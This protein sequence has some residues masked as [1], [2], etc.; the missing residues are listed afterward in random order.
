MRF[1]YIRTQRL[2]I[3]IPTIVDAKIMHDALK[4]SIKDLKQWMPWAQELASLEDTR[5]FLRQAETVWT[6]PLEEH[7]ERSLIIMDVS[8]KQFVGSTGIKPLNLLVPSFEV[9]YWVNQEFAG[10]GFITEA[11]NALSRFLFGELHANRI[12][13]HSEAKNVNSCKVAERLNFTLEGILK[14]HR[15]TADNKHLTDTKLYAQI[16]VEALPLLSVAWK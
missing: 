13:I 8:N 14:N 2:I 4:K 6:G 10:K 16:N 5:Y 3:R 9:G 1:D 15:L 7:V 11:V 12:E